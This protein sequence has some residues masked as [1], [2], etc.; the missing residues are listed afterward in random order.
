MKQCYWK[1]ALLTILVASTGAAHAIERSGGDRDT[2]RGSTWD[3]ETRYYQQRGGYYYQDDNLRA[4]HQELRDDDA[5]RRMRRDF[6]VQ[7]KMNN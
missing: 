2:S 5:E 6:D 7:G 1:A 3:P 4:R